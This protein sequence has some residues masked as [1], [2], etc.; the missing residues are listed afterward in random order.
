V[1]LFFS[2]NWSFFSLIHLALSTYETEFVALAVCTMNLVEWE[3]MLTVRVV[4]V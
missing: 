3:S 2:L 1:W 4:V